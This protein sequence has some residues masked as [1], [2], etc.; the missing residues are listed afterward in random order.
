MRSSENMRHLTSVELVDL[1]E[2]TRAESSAPHLA[3]CEVCRRQLADL[4]VVLSTARRLDVPE[5]SPLFWDHFSA[6]IH[7]AVAAEGAPRGR[8][9]VGWASSL[10]GPV[11]AGTLAALVLAVLVIMRANLGRETIVPT[12][13]PP[14]GT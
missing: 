14:T 2:G 9:W 4:Q 5:P 3:A 8:A 7:Q 13:Q 11:V 10:A 6:Q 1:A 12:G